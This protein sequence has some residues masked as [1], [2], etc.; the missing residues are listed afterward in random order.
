MSSDLNVRQRRCKHN[1][2][3]YAHFEESC[4][5]Q[6]V[7]HRIVGQD[8]QK[9]RLRQVLMHGAVQ[10]ILAR[11]LVTDDSRRNGLSVECPPSQSAR[12]LVN[13]IKSSVYQ[14]C[15]FVPL[16]SLQCMSL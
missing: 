13:M 16:D 10:T 3:R 14:L 6:D 15:T 2:V 11:Y 12:R 5:K 8:A 1:V 7:S 9:R 4:C